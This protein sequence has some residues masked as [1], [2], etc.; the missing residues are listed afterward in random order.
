MLRTA[1]A[2]LVLFTC[3]GHPA[4]QQA[5]AATDAGGDAFKN[6]VRPVLQK[7][8]SPCHEKGGKMY[9]RMP[10]D[11]PS[12]L[13]SHVPGVRKRLKGDDLA[14]FEAWLTASP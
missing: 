4:G 8:C 7:S 11:D 13:R 9:A 12:T 3:S 10:F 2:S 14:T 6:S 1:F 5:P